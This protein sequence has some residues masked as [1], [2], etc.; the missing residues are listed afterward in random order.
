MGLADPVDSSESRNQA[1]LNTANARPRSLV[2]ACD[3]RHSPDRGTLRLIAKLSG[4]SNR[5]LLWLRH[6]QAP[7]AHTEAWVTQLRNLPQIE[8]KIRDDAESVM[9]WLERHHD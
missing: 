1:L 9:H 5:T 3:A 4:Y 6:S 8:L 7:H 2:L